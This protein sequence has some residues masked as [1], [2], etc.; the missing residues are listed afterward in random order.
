MN[1]LLREHWD[2]ALALVAVTAGLLL[3][4]VGWFGAS[5]EQEVANQIPY[6][7]SGGIGGL[8]L[9][10]VAVALW[11][12]ADLRDQW[13][14]LDDL[15]RAVTTP[16]AVHAGH[17]ALVGIN[18]TEWFHLDTCQLVD[19]KDVVRLGTDLSGRTPCPAC[20]PPALT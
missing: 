2:R 18:G 8:F 6:L 10:G 15:Q 7:I 4:A 16:A 12:S 14:K 20:R 19:G 17:P 9:L 5:G 11:I 13:H 3:I 1:R